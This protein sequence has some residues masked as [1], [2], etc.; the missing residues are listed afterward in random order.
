MLSL[1]VKKSELKKLFPYWKTILIYSFL[2]IVIPFAAFNLGLVRVSGSLGAMIVGS[3]PAIAIIMAVAF[4][5]E[6]YFTKAKVL[7]MSLGMFA[8]VLLSFS[9]KNDGANQ[10]IGVVLLLINCICVCLS[11]IYIKK[12]TQIKFSVTLNFIQILIGAIIVTTIGF[13]TEEFSFTVFSGNAPLLFDLIYLSF[14]TAGATTIWLK[15]VQEPN[16]E[17]S[18]IFIWK[19]LIPLFGA[20]FSWIITD[21]D[22]P[23]KL[24]IIALA[25]ILL[26]IFIATRTVKRANKRLLKVY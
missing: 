20:I 10:I 17:I 21:G 26:S 18:V 1:F 14:I 16:V 15:L 9:K 19:L 5:S 12:Q 22:N 3:S 2:K 4:I 23:T 13:L 25:M 8:I 24:S 7:S 11:D 6:E